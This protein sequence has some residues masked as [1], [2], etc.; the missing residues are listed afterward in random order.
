MKEMRFSKKNIILSIL[1]FVVFLLM[2]V[3]AHLAIKM[4][5]PEDSSFIVKGVEG[6]IWNGSALQVVSN[7]LPVNPINHVKW[8]INPLYFFTGKLGGQFE[9]ND[10]QIKAGGIWK[11]G[12]NGDILL[13][14]LSAELPASTLARKLPFRSSKLEGT[15]RLSFESCL[16][17]KENGLSQVLGDINWKKAGLQLRGPYMSLGNFAINLS[18]Q[19][20]GSLLVT[21]KKAKNV[22]DLKGTAQL[23][24]SS[25]D[26]NISVTNNVPDTI[27]PL[28]NFMKDEGANRKKFQ[29]TLPVALKF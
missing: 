28:L 2:F 13:N 24:K 19:D 1:L 11:L 12:F 9:I 26:A 3:P 14:D 18:S 29:G 25:L 4:I 7:D 20:D 5:L 15:I 23:K 22:L 8:R 17:S 10:Q 27:K 16:Y 21:A 6:S